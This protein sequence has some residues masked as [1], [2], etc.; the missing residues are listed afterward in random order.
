[1]VSQRRERAA[2]SL[3]LVLMAVSTAGCRSQQ[4]VLAEQQKALTS[5][6]ATTRALSDAWLSGTV[7]GTYVRTA[8]EAT[9][10][11]VEKQ[12]AELVASPDMLA[13]PQH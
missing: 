4:Q 3:L 7:S 9:Q 8:L 13:D 11:L 10:R 1:M 6:Q 12:R 2:P 5:L